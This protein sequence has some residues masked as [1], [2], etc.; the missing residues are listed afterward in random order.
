MNRSNEVQHEREIDRIERNIQNY[1]EQ[2]RKANRDLKRVE[3]EI[4]L[5]D[6]ELQ[7]LDLEEEKERKRQMIEE[8]EKINQEKISKLSQV[9]TANFLR[10]QLL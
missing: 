7:I 1:D 2:I 3:K 8:A 9:Q 5:N 10:L 4:E 6:W